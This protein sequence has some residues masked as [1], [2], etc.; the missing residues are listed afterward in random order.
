MVIADMPNGE[1][2]AVIHSRHSLYGRIPLRAMG[3]YNNFPAGPTHPEN[4]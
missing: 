2:V 3:R 4:I 1:K